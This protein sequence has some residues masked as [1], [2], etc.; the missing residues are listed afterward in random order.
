VRERI[1][2]ALAGEVRLVALDVD[3]VLTD[4]GLYIGQTQQGE[5]IELKRFHIMDGLGIKFL[6]WSGIQVVLVSGRESDATVLRA[7]ELGVECYQD[8]GARKLP[9]M[10]EL[11][12][13]HEM[14][15]GQVAFVSDDLADL[16]VL[17]RVGLPVAVANAAPEVKAVARWI[18]RRPGGSGAVRE[19]AEQLLTVRGE[20]PRLVQEYRRARE[21]AGNE[22]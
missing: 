12:Q 8:A 5:P 14:T 3:G 6:V 19:F 15:W 7:R 22:R 18:T 10:E 4:G 2:L 17:E 16:P 13:R 1:P 9:V 20:W 21:G 11:L